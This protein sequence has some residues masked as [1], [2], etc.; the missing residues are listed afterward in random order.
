M[1]KTQQKKSL[2]DFHLPVWRLIN[3]TDFK[4]KYFDTQNKK[5][6]AHNSGISKMVLWKTRKTRTGAHTKTQQGT[7]LFTRNLRQTS[8]WLFGAWYTKLN[9]KSKTLTHEKQ[10]ENTHNVG[11]LKTFLWKK[12]KYTWSHAQDTTR[13]YT[14]RKKQSLSDSNL[15][16]WWWRNLYRLQI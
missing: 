5:N 9:H 10:K 2:S 13:H 11:T 16:V 8:I 6:N 12:Q 14:F 1:K 4:A 7:K 3:Q 15:V